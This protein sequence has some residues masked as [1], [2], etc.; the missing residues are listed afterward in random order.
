MLNTIHDTQM[1]L[2]EP[3]VI[4]PGIVDSKRL[5]MFYVSVKEGSF[6][7]AAQILSVSPSAISHAMKS[8]EEDLGCSLFRRLG[9]QVKPTGA[10]VRL[11]PMVEDLLV[12]MSSMRSELA[13]LDGRTEKLIFRLPS[14]LLGM[15]RAGSLSTF[16]ECFP[17]ADLEIMVTGAGKDESSRR[18]AD[19][20]MDFMERVPKDMVRRDLVNENYHAYV[21][22]FHRLGQKSRVSVDELRQGL[23]IFQ[24][25]FILKALAHHLGRG[26]EGD[27]RKWV[28]PDPRVA[29]E[30]ACQG[31]G[32]VFLPDWAA[33]TAVQ[34]GALV[35]LKLPGITLRRTCCAWWDPARPLTW[36]AEVFLNL[37]SE[38]ITREEGSD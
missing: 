26:G 7:G 23:L 37:L 38:S 8:L 29:H 3:P 11:L 12:K 2:R 18:Q 16:H 21:A 14:C 35:C 33:A 19:F 5:Q 13:A 34:E 6:A 10:A 27:L 22:P 25:P 1:T 30:L 32:I 36:V 15:L 4:D 17:A 28:L 31:Q 20:E 24:D 9:P